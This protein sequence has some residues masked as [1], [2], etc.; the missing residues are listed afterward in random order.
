[1]KT[2]GLIGKNISYSFSRLYF[3]NKFEKENL[4][5]IEYVN[6][7]IEAI[8]NVK[9]ILQNE[10]NVGFNV[11][12]PY[13]EEMLPFLDQLDE[14]AQAIGAVNVIVKKEGKTIGSN[15]DW[16][17]FLQSLP[18]DVNKLHK[19]A[20]VLGTGGASKAIVY[21]LQQVG[22]E[23]LRVSRFKKDGAISYKDLTHELIQSHTLI[24]H[25][26]PIGTFPQIEKSIDF[27]FEHITEQHYVYD[28]IYNPEETMFL[29]K[30]KKRGA[31]TQNGY[32]MLI[33]QAEAAWK[34]WGLNN[35]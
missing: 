2:L 22:I 17:G 27:P 14:H 34:M 3:T 29:K 1:M 33:Y 4:S 23:A 11:T 6:F 31:R 24:I 15:T 26:T 13:K 16:I 32:L 19:K 28:L 12:I 10:K 9:D 18:D 20:L 8:S 5:K 25:T 7:D 35:L 21:A 30:A